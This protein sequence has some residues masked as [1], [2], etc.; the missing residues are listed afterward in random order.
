[1]NFAHGM[2]ALSVSWAAE[3]EGNMMLHQK[4]IGIVAVAAILAG[5]DR[6]TS[7]PAPSPT[8]GASPS[9]SG[10]AVP[11]AS[12]EGWPTEDEVKAAI[13]KVEYDIWASQTNKDVWHVKDMK[14]EVHSVKLGLNTT[15]KQMTYGAQAITVYPAKVLYTRVTEYTS[16]PAVREEGGADGVWFLYKDSFGQWTAKYGNE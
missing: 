3:G 13:L 10:A 12:R 7:S 2:G 9:P 4:A 15:Q 14:H 16:K 11:Q 6:G 1:M 8:A 5:C